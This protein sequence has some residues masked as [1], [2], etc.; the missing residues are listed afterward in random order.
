MVAALVVG[1]A[2]EIRGGQLSAEAA[3]KEL[4]LRAELTRSQ[5]VL[6][7]VDENL[8]SARKDLE[9]TQA[10]LAAVEP[11]I[12]EGII[13][14]TAGIRREQDFSTT[15]LNREA[16]VPLISGKTSAERLRLYGGDFLDYHVFCSGSP[17]P[18]NWPNALSPR[19]IGLRM[20]RLEVGSRRYEL[21][22]HGRHMLIGPIGTP[23]EA[24]VLNPGRLA[25]CI[26]K[27]LVESADR[28][29]IAQELAPLVQ[30]VR[31]ARERRVQ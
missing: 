5:G 19:R 10:R 2:K 27:I 6:A 11:S 22:E 23:M 25:G 14:A 28:T 3:R 20:L 29:R 26:V 7:K 12:L 4:D 24:K 1:I 18:A 8:A 21:N 17:E 30:A 13:V 15:H 16:V 9:A 31:A